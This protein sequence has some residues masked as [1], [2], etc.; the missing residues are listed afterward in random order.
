MRSMSRQ[1]QKCWYSQKVISGGGFDRKES[2][3]K[4]VMEYL[5]VSATAGDVDNLSAG[6]VPDY[7][8]VITSFKKLPVEEG[9]V[10]WIDRIPD[11]DESGD[12]NLD[13]NGTPVTLPD[14][15]L[16]KILETQK[17]KVSRFG[18]A[19]IGGT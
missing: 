15:T 6:L 13:E 8:R 19:R 9:F 3:T 11:I 1:R 4:P 18:I 12:L 17:G 14:Y 5:V 2:Y 10:W 16:S 7:E